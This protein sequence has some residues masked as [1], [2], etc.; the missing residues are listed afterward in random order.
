MKVKK[1]PISNLKNSGDI[2]TVRESISKIYGVKT[3]RVDTV[4]NTITVDYDDNVN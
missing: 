1:F 3:V 2:S 4:S